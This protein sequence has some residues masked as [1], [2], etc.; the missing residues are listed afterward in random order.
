[1]Q[2]FVFQNPTKVIFGQNIIPQTGV[3]TCQF[4]SRVLLVTG[5]SSAK[6]SSL[7]ND[8]TTSILESGGTVFNL[9]G[10]RP[11]PTLTKVREGIELVRKENIEV[12]CGLGGGSVIDSA[13]AIGAGSVVEHDVW[14]F[15]T[16]KKSVRTTLPVIAIPTLAASGSEMNSGMV[17]TNS[18]TNQKFG[19]ANRYLFPKTA[20]M[21]PQTTF[22]VPPDHT[23][24]GCIDALTHI[25]EFY[26]TNAQPDSAVQYHYMEGLAKTLFENCRPA[27]QDPTDYQARANLMWSS[28]LTLNGFCASGLGKVGFPMHL[29]EH[30]LSALYDIPHGAGLAIIGPGWM[31]YHHEAADGRMQQFFKRTAEHLYE[32][33]GI[34]ETIRNLRNWYESLGAPTYLEDIGVDETNFPEITRNSQALAKVW[35]MR[36]YD[37]ELVGKILLQCLRKTN[38]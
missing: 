37:E 10:I 12:I 25:F 21:D 26:F 8:V 27:L 6:K 32:S 18:A 2:N 22:T 29:I 28:A 4:G 15:F 35:R 33:S 36:E 14:K 5:I 17:L 19:F 3:E 24:Y 34:L 13:K 1:M 20:I 9:E 11:N 23:A 16:G 30:S 7:F 31:K 38:R